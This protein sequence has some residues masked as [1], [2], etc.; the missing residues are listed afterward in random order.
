MYR[1]FSCFYSAIEV[2]RLAFNVVEV[3]VLFE[4]TRF[5][6]TRHV[7]EYWSTENSSIWVKRQAVI[8][9]DIFKLAAFC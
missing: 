6:L 9:P 7:H 1:K 8:G 2:R 5:G 3:A 4:L